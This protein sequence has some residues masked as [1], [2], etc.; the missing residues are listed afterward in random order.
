MTVVDVNVMVGPVPHQ[1]V[2]IAGVADLLRRMDSAG[3]S[4]A[5]VYGSMARYGDPEEGSARL[6]GHLAREETG[7]RLVPTWVHAPRRGASPPEELWAR[8]VRAVRLFPRTHGFPLAQPR[9]VAWLSRWAKGGLPVMVD[10]DEVGYED[11]R[12]L[13]ARVPEAILVLCH[14]GYRRLAEVE[15]LLEEFPRVLVDTAYL[16][17]HRGLERLVGAFGVER[18]VFGSGM[19][20]GDLGGA[21]AAVRWSD[22]SPQDQAAI[23]GRG[24]E[25][26]GAP[27]AGRGEGGEG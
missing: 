16:A 5:L 21:L 26:T 14:V 19:P 13:L 12:G 18:V 8:G 7:G 11:V 10:L 15:A 25:W 1:P 27:P 2:W 9:V 17:S 4:Q 23:L 24:R 22:L 3:V 20:F 6:V